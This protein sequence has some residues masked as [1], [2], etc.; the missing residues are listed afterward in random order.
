LKVRYLRPAR[1]ELREAI[2]YYEGLRSGLGRDF[3]DEVYSTV[4][5]IKALPLAWRPIGPNARRCLTRR[6]PYGVIYALEGDEV[7][8]I[9]VAHTHRDPS[10]WKDRN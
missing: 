1:H 10:Y 9:A 8:V 4:E 5:R 2:E 7:I 6:F 3:R